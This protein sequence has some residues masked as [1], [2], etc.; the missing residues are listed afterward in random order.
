MTLPGGYPNLL[1]PGDE[2][3]VAKGYGRNAGRLV[4]AKRNYDPDNVFCSAISLP[5]GAAMAGVS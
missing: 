3:R 2:D 1:A 4:K 5:V